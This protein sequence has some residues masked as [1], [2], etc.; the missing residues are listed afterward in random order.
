[1]VGA[2]AQFIPRGGPDGVHAV[3]H[4]ADAAAAAA[5]G[6]MVFAREAHVAMAAG[7]AQRVPAKVELGPV[8][9]AFLLCHGQAKVGPGEVPDSGEAAAQHLRP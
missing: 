8:Q 7:L 6:L 4:A 1:M 5:V 9:Q 3:G 2:L